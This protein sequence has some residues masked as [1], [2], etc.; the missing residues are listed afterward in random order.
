MFTGMLAHALP[1]AA[2]PPR[3][4]ALPT[5]PSRQLDPQALS[6][7]IDSLYR[8][9]RFMCGSRE[10]AE[11][12]VQETFARVLRKPRQLRADDDLGYLLRVLRNTWVSGRR[13][14]ARRPQTMPLLETLDLFE[15]RAAS[16]PELSVEL[17]ELYEAVATLPD[18]FREALI[19]VDMLGLSYREAG[20]LMGVGEA[21]VTTRLY[22]ARQRLARRLA[23]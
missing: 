11:D 3:G 5:A 12:L 14:A 9:A 19:A 20:D 2:F 15:D 10:D 23:C 8:A 4:R 17:V 7:H 1:T 16:N 21:T 6:R 18:T 22:R 13:A